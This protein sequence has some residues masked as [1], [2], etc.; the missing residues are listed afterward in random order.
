[1]VGECVVPISLLFLAVPLAAQ[2]TVSPT[3]TTRLS[4]RLAQPG[5]ADVEGDYRFTADGMRMLF[6]AN[7]VDTD[8]FEL[9]AAPAD[10]GAP[11]ERLAPGV[12]VTSFAPAAGGRVVFVADADGTG[13]LELFQVPVAGGVPPVQLSGAMVAGG[14]V[15]SFQLTP[16]GT[17]AL[18][19]A[20]MLVDGRVELFSVPVDASSAPVQLDPAPPVGDGDVTRAWISPDGT[21]VLFARARDRKS[22]V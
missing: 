7:T 18:F 11:A 13:M 6:R 8:V 14:D 19:L 2:G 16:D 17:R 4:G 20:D 9:Y 5:A 15:S 22:V 1:M 3:T 21:H 10:A 12:D